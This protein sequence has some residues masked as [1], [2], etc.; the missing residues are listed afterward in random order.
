[1]N[2]DA[3]TDLEDAFSVVGLK[4]SLEMPRGMRAAGEKEHPPH[5]I[6]HRNRRPAAPEPAGRVGAE[7]NHH[8]HHRPS[9]LTAERQHNREDPGRD[10]RG[11]DQYSQDGPGVRWHSGG[12]SVAACNEPCSFL[13][14]ASSCGGRWDNYRLLISSAL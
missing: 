4:N 10:P 6:G 1:M 14:H 13:S 2:T 12:I 5:E 9:Q 3:R 11:K 8:T 7:S